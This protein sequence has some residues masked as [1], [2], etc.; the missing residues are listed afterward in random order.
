MTVVAAGSSQ[1]GMP[2]AALRSWVAKWPWM[3]K[4]AG[5]RPVITAARL[6]EQTPEQT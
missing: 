2:R 4:R 1:L 6:G 3:P 5:K